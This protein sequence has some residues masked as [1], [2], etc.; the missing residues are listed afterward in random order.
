[1]AKLTTIEGIGASFAEKL[2]SIGVN[3]TETLSLIHI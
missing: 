2:N 1:M 3:S